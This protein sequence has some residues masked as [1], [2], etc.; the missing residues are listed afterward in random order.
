MKWGTDQG[1]RHGLGLEPGQEAFMCCAKHRGSPTLS[2]LLHTT[3]VNQ[4]PQSQPKLPSEKLR[5]S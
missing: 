5:H 4:T 1:A 3:S 2:F